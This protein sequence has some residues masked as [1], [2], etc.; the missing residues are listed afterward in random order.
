MK[1][2]ADDKPLMLRRAR[3]D[4]RKHAAFSG[5]ACDCTPGR[6]RKGRVYGCPKGKRC[7]TCRYSKRELAG[8][9]VQERREGWV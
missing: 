2:A 5:P 9:T 4:E 1:R 3:E 8:R 7:P 6:F